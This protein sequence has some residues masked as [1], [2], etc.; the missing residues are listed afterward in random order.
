[1]ARP[2]KYENIE[3]VRN[4]VLY[5]Y[6]TFQELPSEREISRVTGVPKSSVGNIMKKLAEEG[7][8]VSTRGQ[9][10]IFSDEKA[11]RESAHI[12]VI[13][14]ISCGLRKLAIQEMTDYITL[15]GRQYREGYYFLIADGESMIDA[16]IETGDYVLIRE[17]PFAE[18]GQIVVALVGEEATLKRYYPN[19]EEGFADLVP[20]NED[21]E[22]QR[23]SLDGPD[24]LIIQGVAVRVVKV[25][26]LK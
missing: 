24:A 2:I 3:L 23:V 6:E 8:I 16:G 5:Y 12:P 18:K 11:K 1:M 14:S 25:R 21:M 19:L 13:G 10:Y 26:E 22:A 20:E 15:P 7:I 9:Q 17:Q 4:S